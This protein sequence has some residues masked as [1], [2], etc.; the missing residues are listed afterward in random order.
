MR[1]NDH[2]IISGDGKNR[3]NIAFISFL[4]IFVPK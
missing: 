1:D 2:F 4:G 3:E